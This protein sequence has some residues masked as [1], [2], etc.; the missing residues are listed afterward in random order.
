MISPEPEQ[1]KQ[2][3][4]S[5]KKRIQWWFVLNAGPVI[6][7]LLIQL[8]GRTSKWLA[9]DS[10][11]I[12]VLIRRQRPFII[13]FWHSRIML[14]PAIFKFEGG[15]MSPIVMISSSV[16][17]LFI[18]RLVR[19]FKI[20]TAFG[21]S[22]RGGR[23]ALQEMT[24]KHKE[25]KIILAITPDGPR[26]PRETIKPGPIIMGRDTGLP[27]IGLTYHA[28][29]VRRLNS[30]DRFVVVWPFN[31]IVWTATDPVTVPPDANEEQMESCRKELE[32]K[33]RK[34]TALCEEVAE[35]KKSLEGI[36][37]FTMQPGWFSNRRRYTRADGTRFDIE[38]LLNKHP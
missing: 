36:P 18:S 10:E 34:A 8:V 25:E 16:D 30:W 24:D 33:M 7:Y 3:K 15:Q 29:K 23:D 37:H 26:G 17:G 4:P 32:D 38:E 35:G 13:V 22:T 27:V 19:L 1:N 14:L 11:K 20:D 9:I 5:L 31:T 2:D 6:G 12:H 21:S 28:K